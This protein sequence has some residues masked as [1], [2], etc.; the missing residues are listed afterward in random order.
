M[1][2]R[3]DSWRAADLLFTARKNHAAASLDRFVYVSGGT[4][5]QEQEARSVEYYDPEDDLWDCAPDMQHSR[6]EHGMASLN[7]CL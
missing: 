2:E 7:G 4:S 1:T 5:D 3:T 6:T